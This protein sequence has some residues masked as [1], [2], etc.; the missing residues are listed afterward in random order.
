MTAANGHSEIVDPVAP[1][2]EKRHMTAHN[3]TSI[4]TARTY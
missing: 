2:K 3:C 4:M 1:V